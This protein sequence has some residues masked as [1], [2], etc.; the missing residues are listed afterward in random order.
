V[1][2]GAVPVRNAALR[3]YD[4]DADRYAVAVTA[5]PSA[6]V[7]ALVRASDQRMIEVCPEGSATL[8]LYTAAGIG[9]RVAAINH[10]PSGCR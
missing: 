8:F 10:V 5:D 4:F 7:R 2:L 9:A 3:S 6:A 1:Y